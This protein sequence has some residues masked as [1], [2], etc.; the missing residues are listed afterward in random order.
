MSAAALLAPSLLGQNPLNRSAGGIAVT[1]NLTGLGLLEGRFD[2]FT[3]VNRFFGVPYAQAP[4]GALRFQ[5]PQPVQPWTGVK[6]A[7]E[8][9]PCPQ[10]GWGTIVGSEDCLYMDIITPNS[11]IPSQP[12][13][14]PGGTYPTQVWV[15]GGG[16]TLESF[17]LYQLK[18]DYFANND[19][20]YLPNSGKVVTV[21]VRYRVDM[22]GF[23][24][25]PSLKE[26]SLNT[27]SYG[28]YGLLDC[29]QALTFIQGNIQFFGGQSS[30]VTI[31]G[32]SAG[33]TL[34]GC[35]VA[36]PLTQGLITGAIGESMWNLNGAV[37]LSQGVRDA[38]G[39]MVVAN[40]G[41]GSFSS[42]TETDSATLS[43]I[44]ACLRGKT[45]AEI[46]GAQ[47]AGGDAA[48]ASWN[49]AHS[50]TM[51]WSLLA[52][53]GWQYYPTIDGYALTMAPID[54]WASG[55][56]NNVAVIIGEN[57]DEWS[58]GVQAVPDATGAMLDMGTFKAVVASGLTATS[59]MAEFEAAWI[60]YPASD[61][62]STV[63]DGYF[64][65]IVD[66]YQRYVVAGTSGYFSSN[67]GM[68][69][70]ALST[71]TGRGFGT[72]HRYV[73]GEGLRPA[74]AAIIPSMGALHTSELNYIWGYHLLNRNFVTDAMAPSA[75]VLYAAYTDAQNAMGLTMHKYWSNMFV[76]GTPN[77]AGD[78]LPDWL[79]YTASAGNTILFKSEI[80]GG[81]AVNP[82]AMLYSC[83]PEPFYN[84]RKNVQAFFQS[85]YSS[86]QAA[87][88]PM[89]TCTTPVVGY[90]HAPGF[91][92][93]PDYSF[94]EVTMNYAANCSIP[95]SA[96]PGS[97]PCC[98]YSRSR[99]RDLLFGSAAGP[100]CRQ[101]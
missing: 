101:C 50:T 28:N 17:P 61:T 91:V 26:T 21:F 35:L 96:Y 6:S 42:D 90:S 25:H 88:A 4:V 43:S 89:Q 29:I 22:L 46:L 79:P 44:A 5:P 75:G 3:S 52:W 99:K 66:P 49:T 98:Q 60:N 51:G 72:T 84:F 64:G 57:S 41:C 38:A 93:N 69:L 56:N 33:A 10:F 76:M 100:S 2:R 24:S 70:D 71:Q 15:H 32:E 63:I 86:T 30:R 53:Q 54:A 55:I 31:Q 18:D 73:F 11:G 14:P 47:N 13:T 12:A 19:L 36:S 68:L 59:T 87:A 48:V 94:S 8:A 1:A 58:Y 62:Y 77:V 74:A 20:S 40:L 39:S 45:V 95:I 65:G 9:W 83:L 97:L 16:M 81:A 67:I 7:Y 78:E 82:C 37:H 85:G 92:M 27:A 34:V 80:P 23:M